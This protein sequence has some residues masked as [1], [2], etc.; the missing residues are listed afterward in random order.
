MFC[1]KGFDFFKWVERHPVRVFAVI[2]AIF[3][4]YGFAIPICFYVKGIDAKSEN[5]S[6]GVPQSER[7][8]RGRMVKNQIPW[9]KC[10]TFGDTFGALTCLF[11][12]LTCWG[13]LYTLVYQRKQTEDAHTMIAKEKLPLVLLQAKG[14][15]LLFDW[16]K[17]GCRFTA[18]LEFSTAEEN[19]SDFA[20]LAI[21]H[22][23]RLELPG[24]VLIA[25]QKVNTSDFLRPKDVFKERIEYFSPLK[26]SRL[27]PFLKAVTARSRNDRPVLELNRVYRNFLEAYAAV[28]QKYQIKCANDESLENGRALVELIERGGGITYIALN[29]LFKG[30]H[31]LDLGI[32]VIHGD[33]MA[34]CISKREYDQFNVVL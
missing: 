15:K 6:N 21:R 3:V 7:E 33:G 20:A 9:D 10:G 12:A 26:S 22:K 11:S 28:D 25:T 32:D 2:A 24:S 17:S 34:K 13:M 1:A 4:L 30:E 5:E 14:G 18:K 23:G 19:A 31:V 16:D 8:D 29:N 27:L